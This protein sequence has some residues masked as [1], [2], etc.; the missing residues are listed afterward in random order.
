MK[1]SRGSVLGKCSYWDSPSYCHC[2]SYRRVPITCMETAH[3]LV[4]AP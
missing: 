4:Q 3:L 2:C 1:P